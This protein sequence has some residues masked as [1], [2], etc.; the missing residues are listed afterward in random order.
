MGTS[1]GA[2]SGALYS[3][4]YSPLEVAVSF[5]VLLEAHGFANP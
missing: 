1:S 3:A 2:L 5:W 4:G